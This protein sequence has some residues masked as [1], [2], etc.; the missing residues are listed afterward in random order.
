MIS[1]NNNTFIVR[2]QQNTQPFVYLDEVNHFEF[3][4]TVS[5]LYFDKTT[6]EKYNRLDFDDKDYLAV[7]PFEAVFQM[8]YYNAEAAFQRTVNLE[9]ELFVRIRMIKYKLL[10]NRLLKLLKRGKFNKDKIQ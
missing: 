6:V 3:R 9:K 4:K 1:E 7:F 5:E 8:I 2:I 10:T